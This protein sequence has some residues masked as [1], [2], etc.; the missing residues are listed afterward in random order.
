[1]NELEILASPPPE[2]EE[3]IEIFS[4]EKWE[5]KPL[6]DQAKAREEMATVEDDFD[7]FQSM[8]LQVEKRL[9]LEDFLYQPDEEKTAHPE[10]DNTKNK[11]TNIRIATP[12]QTHIPFENVQI[13]GSHSEVQAD[14]HKIS[15]EETEAII[16]AETRS[17]IKKSIDTHLPKIIEKVV[18]EELAKV[19]EQELAMKAASPSS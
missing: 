12:E 9:K 13:S 3:A 7:S 10:L 17:L 4:D 2:N 5:A 8:D 1:M 19:L 18:R 16:R 14:Y 11:I 6:N 15:P